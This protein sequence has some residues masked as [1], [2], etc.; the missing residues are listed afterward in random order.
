[1][2]SSP[3]ERVGSAVRLTVLILMVVGTLFPL[4]FLVVTAFK[5][6][7]EFGTNY[8]LPPLT[9]FTTD[10]LMA[11]LDLVGRFALNSVQVTLITAAIVLLVVVPAVYAF[12]WL[13][14]PGA[15]WL[16]TVAIATLLVPAVLTF[17]PQ[18]ILTKQL[19][20]L[21]DQ[22]GVILPFVATG[23]GV[24]VYLLRSFFSALPFELIEAARLDGA[25]ELQILRRVVLPL[26]V[27]SLV[28]VAVVT[29][30]TAWNAFLWPL[31]VISS[32]SKR[33]ISV[34]VTFL[35]GSTSVPDVPALM[36]GYLAASLPLIIILSLLLRYFVRGLTEG[37]VKG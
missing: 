3:L 18:Y 31:V 20:L 37:A 5:T 16:Y 30:V 8:F 27:P 19:G 9:S 33:L 11:G 32:E 13:V 25:S 2:R 1:M 12:T 22:W 23:I 36:G 34:A 7:S 17:V 15:N 24:A 28:T 10:N 21:N 26:S 29:I 4:Y 6:G 14:F 35:A